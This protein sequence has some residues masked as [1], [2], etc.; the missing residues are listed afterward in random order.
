MLFQFLFQLIR[1]I[2]TVSQY[3]CAIQKC[4]KI[5]PYS[6]SPRGELPE[7]LGEKNVLPL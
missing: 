3:M 2:Y 4:I 5:F 1:S 6:N 7:G